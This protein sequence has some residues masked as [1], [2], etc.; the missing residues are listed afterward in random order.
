MQYIYE[1]LRV[2]RDPGLRVF[3]IENGHL[4]LSHASGETMPFREGHHA[5]ITFPAEDV[6]HMEATW[7]FYQQAS[8]IVWRK[9]M[10]KV[11]FAAMGRFPIGEDTKPESHSTQAYQEMVGVGDFASEW[12]KIG[13]LPDEV[14]ENWTWEGIGHL[15]ELAYNV[16]LARQEE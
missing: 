2:T 9:E 4:I 1:E 15:D 12:D 6:N 14:K 3:L 16:M 8:T 10:D 11:E 13:D 5:G 7:G